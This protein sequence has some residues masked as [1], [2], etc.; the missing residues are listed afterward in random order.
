MNVKVIWE[1]IHDSGEIGADSL[2][3][4]QYKKLLRWICEVTKLDWIRNEIIRD[5]GTESERNCNGRPI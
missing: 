2:Q 5:R 4:A 1:A 3:K